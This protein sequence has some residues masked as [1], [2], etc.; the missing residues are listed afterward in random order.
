MTAIMVVTL[1]SSGCNGNTSISGPERVL[2]FQGG[3]GGSEYYRIPALIT[4]ADGSLIAVADKRWSSLGDLP[5]HIDVVARRSED[6]GKSWSEP[7]TIAGEGCDRGYGDAALVMDRRSGDLLCIMAHGNGFWQS[8]YDD[9]LRIVVSRSSDNGKSWSSPVD[10]TSQLY[11]PECRDSVRKRW[12]G[13]FASSG[14]ALQLR[15]G[16]IMFVMTVRTTPEWGAPSSDYVCYSDDGG[17]TWNVSSGPGD[18]NGDEAKVVELDNGDILMSIRNR[19]QGKRKFSLSKDRGLSWSEPFYQEDLDEPACNGDMIAYTERK[20]E[21]GNTILLHTL[22]HDPG[23]RRNVTLFA[24]MDQGKSWPVRR[25][26]WESYSAYSS[27]TVLQDG[28]IGVLLE[29]GKWDSG[30]PGEDGFRIWFVRLPY[31]WLLD[32]QNK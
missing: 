7:V 10:I 4:A 17:F 9:Y 13:A 6:N 25:T 32:S 21:D 8:D 29:E 12:Y 11:G 30:I 22:P 18:D 23:T 26:L 20:S 14:R 5:S 19:A 15:D 28:T 31:E 27:L 24:S 16:R 2:L 3:D 1:L